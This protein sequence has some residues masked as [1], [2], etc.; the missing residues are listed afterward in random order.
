MNTM[1]YIVEPVR[2]L[3]TWQPI[4]EQATSRTRRVVGEIFAESNGNKIFRYLR[5]TPD[6]Y[7]AC[8][9]G[10]NGFPAFSLNQEEIKQGVIESL[11]RRLPS[12]QREDFPEFLA[13]HRLPSPFVYSDVA[14]LG[15]TGARLPSDGFALIPEFP[16]D[17]VPCEFLLEV[18]GLRHVYR[19]DIRRMSVGDVVTFKIEIG[20]PV[21]SDALAIMHKG[22]HIGYV[23]R[24]I[25]NNFHS[26]LRDHHVKA[27]IERINGKPER[28]LVYLRIQ[29]T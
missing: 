18:A 10:F 21:D 23:N 13:Q 14:L 5:D 28:P 1:N 6:F 12:R 24:A 9:L 11:M 19:D 20:N 25:K 29:V 2:L 27:K 15:Y 17:A 16:K 8:K 4:D 3:L 26:W 7:E 22:R